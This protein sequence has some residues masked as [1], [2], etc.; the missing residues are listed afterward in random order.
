MLLAL[1]FWP[2]VIL[3]TLVGGGFGLPNLIGSGVLNLL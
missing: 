2:F 1:I 3:W